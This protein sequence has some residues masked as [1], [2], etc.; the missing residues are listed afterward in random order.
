MK[1]YLTSN[2]TMFGDLEWPLNAARVP[3][4]SS[5]NEAPVPLHQPEKNKRAKMCDVSSLLKGRRSC[6]ME[7]VT[8]QCHLRAVCPHPGDS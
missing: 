2:G 6:S 8:A 5:L 4:Y 1:R 3:V 7:R